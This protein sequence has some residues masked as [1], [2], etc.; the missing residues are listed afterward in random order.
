M[1]PK[2]SKQNFWGSAW[3]GRGRERAA[4]RIDCAEN[5]GFIYNNLKITDFFLPYSNFKIFKATENMSSSC[6][7]PFPKIYLPF[8]YYYYFKLNVPNSQDKS[9][10]EAEMTIIQETGIWVKRMH[11]SKHQKLIYKRLWKLQP[12]Q[13]QMTKGATK[14]LSCPPPCS[15]AKDVLY[16]P[17]CMKSEGGADGGDWLK[18]KFLI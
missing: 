13:G 16:Q 3:M 11:S 2:I 1:K 6:V 9:M 14:S 17:V 4:L 8:F 7:I 12:P 10:S 5:S 15:Q 18:A